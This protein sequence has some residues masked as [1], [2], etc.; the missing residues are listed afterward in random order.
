MIKRIDQRLHVN[1]LMLD[2]F[3]YG[4]I[5]VRPCRKYMQNYVNVMMTISSAFCVLSRDEEN[6]RKK[7]DLWMYLKERNPELYRN[8]MHTAMGLA[9]RWEGRLSRAAQRIGYRLFQ[10]IIGFN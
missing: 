8:I 1:R 6:Y 3:D 9:L 7:H 4:A 10:K 5:S 2:Y